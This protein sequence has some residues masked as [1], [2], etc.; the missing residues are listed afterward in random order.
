M[1]L[2]DWLRRITG[3][4]QSDPDE[5]DDDQTAA[6]PVVSPAHAA[7]AR[8]VEA[9]DAAERL[10]AMPPGDAVRRAVASLRSEIDPV[11]ATGLVRMLREL[12][13]RGDLDDEA[14]LLLAEYF[15]GRGEADVAA[16]VLETAARRSGD[17]ALR[18]RLGLADLCIERGD[19]DA[20]AR[21]LEELVACELS[22]PG[23]DRKSVV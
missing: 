13:E 5:G 14:G 22:Y 8:K 3:S 6:P 12:S 17:G 2:R 11:A 18:A 4:K 23:A 16:R 7:P 15:Q 1:G 21:W 19:R 20:A 9:V 10:R